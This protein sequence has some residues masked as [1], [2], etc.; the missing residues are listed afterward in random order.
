M[1]TQQQTVYIADDG[2]VFTDETKATA[3][4]LRLRYEV[5]LDEFVASLEDATERAKSRMRN[6][7]LQYLAWKELRAEAEKS[8]KK[9]A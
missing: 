5:E 7:I 6:D 4:E 1:Q 9:A 3:Y 2:K 8:A